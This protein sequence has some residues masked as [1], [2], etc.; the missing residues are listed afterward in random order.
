MREFQG[1]A[2]VPGQPFVVRGAGDD[3]HELI[4]AFRG[5]ADGLNAHAVGRRIELL[6]VFAEL[7]V[8]GEAVVVAHPEAKHVLRGRD[9]RV[10]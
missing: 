8:V 1:D 10:A 9:L 5:F 3:G 4:T 2:L 6:E 7:S